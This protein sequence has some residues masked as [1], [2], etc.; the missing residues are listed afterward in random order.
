M[1]AWMR[2]KF[3]HLVDGAFASSGPVQAQID[4]FQY[5]EVMS[6]SIERVGG[7]ECAE[8]IG[9]AFAHMEQLVEANDTDRITNAFSL[10]SALE[11][12]IDVPHF[13]YEVSDIVAGLVQSH[14]AGRIE[15]ACE[16]IVN[17]RHIN[18]KEDIEAFGSWV[19]SQG[20]EEICLDFSYAN[21]VEKYNNI[22]WGS[23]ANQQMRQWIYQ[24][25][26]EFAW[27]KMKSLAI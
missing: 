26:S 27:C 10:C 9:N 14:R 7:D 6:R 20:D 18:A 22:E 3:P 15:T 16:F 4:F 17:E 12:P 25:C 11:M 23:I 5:K 1:A 21:S 8:I 13:F 24:T 19:V 2:K